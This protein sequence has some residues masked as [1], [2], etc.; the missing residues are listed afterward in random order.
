MYQTPVSH[1]LN[2]DVQELSKEPNRKSL[3]QEMER[4]IL[5]PTNQKD[6][7]Y[8][9]VHKDFIIDGHNRVDHVDESL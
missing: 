2:V 7:A 4:K 9:D 6:H 3:D 1:D 5:K 8:V